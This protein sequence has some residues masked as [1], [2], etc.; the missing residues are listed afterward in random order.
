MIHQ[1]LQEMGGEVPKNLRNDE[2]T[3]P[4]GDFCCG[5]RLCHTAPPDGDYRLEASSQRDVPSPTLN[6]GRRFILSILED[7]QSRGLYV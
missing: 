4:R 6:I 3:F 5:P 1:F 7:Y 2:K